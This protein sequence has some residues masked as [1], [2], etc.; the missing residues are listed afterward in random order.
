MST[1][2]HQKLPC[3]FFTLEILIRLKCL[4]LNV[5]LNS[6]FQDNV[7]TKRLGL[8]WLHHLHCCSHV[9]ILC[10]S[11]VA[12]GVEIPLTVTLVENYE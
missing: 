9:A 3:A 4:Y 5:G 8:L 11:T 7:E 10:L 12:G 2:Q 1:H 6:P